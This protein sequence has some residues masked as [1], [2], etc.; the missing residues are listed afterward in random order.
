MSITALQDVAERFGLVGASPTHIGKLQR[1]WG[2][3]K[4]SPPSQEEEKEG[5]EVV[6][7]SGARQVRGLSYHSTFRCFMPL[8]LAIL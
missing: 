1:I 5:Q 7:P 6:I 3:W 2:V 8:I 4:R